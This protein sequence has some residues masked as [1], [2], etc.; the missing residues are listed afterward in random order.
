M[1]LVSF[2]IAFQA[3]LHKQGRI[4]GSNWGDRPPKTYKSNFFHHDF[5]QF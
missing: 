4:Q 2:V 5:V 1:E 3:I